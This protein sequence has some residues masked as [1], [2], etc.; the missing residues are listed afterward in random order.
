MK[1]CKFDYI[2]CAKNI[3]I[4][5]IIFRKINI[6]LNLVKNLFKSK[7]DFVQISNLLN[8]LKLLLFYKNIK[9]NIYN[10]N[11]SLVLYQIEKKLYLTIFIT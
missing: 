10:Q 3:E 6:F 1:T 8:F 4:F 7:L 9:I 2:V 5:S 11:Y